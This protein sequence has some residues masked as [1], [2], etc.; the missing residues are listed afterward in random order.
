MGSGMYPPGAYVTLEHE[1]ILVFR[2]GGKRVFKSVPEK[3]NRRRS[4]YF[5]EE[6][7]VW[8]SDV[9]DFK[10]VRQA[11]ANSFE[12]DLR[13]RSA[14][15]PFEL[16]YRLINM[17][18]VKNDLVL[19]PFLGTGTTLFAAAASC[20]NAVGYDLDE[21]L[22]AQ[23]PKALTEQTVAALNKRIERRFQEHHAFVEKRTQE[24][25]EHAFKYRSEC[26]DFP[27]MTRQ[28][29]EIFIHFLKN[30][31]SQTEGVFE[32][33]YHDTPAQSA[34]RQKTLF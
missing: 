24:K 1:Y 3:L 30:I 32:A 17:F 16:A 31:R 22:T 21:G 20:R 18:S 11:L 8:F 6:R 14:A 12:K 19:D 4:A 29:R 33:S 23:I 13:E 15:F 9:W 28:E 10:G 27:L 25:G 26:Y 7:N 2:K 34:T 5:W